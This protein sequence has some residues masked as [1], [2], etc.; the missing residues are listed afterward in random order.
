MKKV[1]ACS[2]LHG[3]KGFLDAIKE[4]IGEND[5]VYFL[6]DAADRGPDGWEMIKEILADKRFIYI[7]G[8]HEDMLIKAYD[9]YFNDDGNDRDIQLWMWNGGQPTFNAMIADPEAEEIV[10]KLRE[11]PIHTI[12]TNSFKELILL[13][14]AGQCPDETPTYKEYI[15]DR[16]HFFTSW[17]K[18]EQYN[19]IFVVHGHTP[20]PHLVEELSFY[21]ETLGS[22]EIEPGALFYARGHKICIDCGAVFTGIST[23]LNLDT[24]DEEIF[25]LN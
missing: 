14:H 11:L 22:D 6:G 15:W 8:N 3:V 18:S 24:F 4:K 20:V 17:P 13:S 12:Y 25:C 16:T 9:D 1:W 19:D 7:K 2:D 10:G 21:E 23:L 5:V